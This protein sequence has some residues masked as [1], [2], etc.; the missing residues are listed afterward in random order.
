[1]V[2]Q[3]E[4][5]FQQNLKLI[6]ETTMNHFKVVAS[7]SVSFR[8]VSVR[9]RLKNWDK[10]GTTGRSLRRSRRKIQRWCARLGREGAQDFDRARA[11][12]KSIAERKKCVKSHQMR[13]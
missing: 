1:M 13:F 9:C 5:S 7:V 4:I 6:A 10:N 12:L 3:V 8:F 2:N 11:R